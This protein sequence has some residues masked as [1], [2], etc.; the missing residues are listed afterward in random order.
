MSNTDEYDCM[1]EPLLTML[2]AEAGTSDVAGFLDDEITDHFG[3]SPGL[4]ETAPIAARLTAW[5]RD[6]RYR[7]VESG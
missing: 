2:A 5:W 3:L 1:I 6:A 7:E 4:V